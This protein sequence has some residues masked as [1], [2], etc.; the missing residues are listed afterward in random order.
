MLDLKR[1]QIRNSRANEQVMIKRMVDDYNEE[2]AML[3]L[4]SYVG[5]YTFANYEKYLYGKL[6]IIYTIFLLSENIFDLSK[7]RCKLKH[8]IKKYIFIS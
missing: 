8:R 4:K 6:Y 5:P 1:I 3:G 7:S 2:G